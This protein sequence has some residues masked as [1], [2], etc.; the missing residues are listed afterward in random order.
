LTG[1]PSGKVIKP[2]SGNADGIAIA[3]VP[4]ADIERFER[5]HEASL[6]ELASYFNS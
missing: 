6:A 2:L 4:A 1:A 3:P 5:R